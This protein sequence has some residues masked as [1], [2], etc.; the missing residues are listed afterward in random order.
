MQAALPA[1]RSYSTAL[2]KSPL[3]TKEVFK[4]ASPGRQLLTT[5]TTPSPR[6][7]LSRYTW[8]PFCKLCTFLP[9]V[10]KSFGLHL[11]SS[12]FLQCI[13]AGVIRWWCCLGANTYMS[14]TGLWSC[15]LWSFSWPTSSEIAM[16]KGNTSAIRSAGISGSRGKVSAR[17]PLACL[18]QPTKH[19]VLNKMIMLPQWY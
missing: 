18:P 8:D 6:K 9:Q 16:C 19:Q 1:H 10:K 11:S 4:N 15:P 17:W 3:C 2:I 13:K 5:Q 12:S 7:I 14:G